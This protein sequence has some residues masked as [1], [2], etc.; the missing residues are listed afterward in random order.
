MS[1]VSTLLFYQTHIDSHS[2]FSCS[3]WEWLCVWCAGGVH[4][5]LSFMITYLWHLILHDEMSFTISTLLPSHTSSTAYTVPSG[6]VNVCLCGV[7]AG[8]VYITP[9]YAVMWLVMIVLPSLLGGGGQIS[10]LGMDQVSGHNSFLGGLVQILLDGS[11][12]FLGGRGLYL[13]DELDQFPVSGQVLLA[14]VLQL[15]FTLEDASSE[16]RKDNLH[17]H[18]QNT[19]LDLFDRRSTLAELRFEALELAA[20]DGVSLSA[21]QHRSHVR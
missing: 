11:V 14:D 4:T 16:A 12:F 5:T 17:D 8:V 18:L 7:R 19:E 15:L 6:T 9:S 2:E 3:G 1:V 21:E 10:I 13:L 20:D